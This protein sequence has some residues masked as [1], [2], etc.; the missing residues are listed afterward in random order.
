[1]CEN[2]NKQKE[3]QNNHQFVS[4]K[5]KQ[6]LWIQDSWKHNLWNPASH[7]PIISIFY[8]IRQQW[9]PLEKI[10]DF[11]EVFNPL[12]DIFLSKSDPNH[13]WFSGFPTSLKLTGLGWRIFRLFWT[14]EEALLW[15][16]VISWEL[17][18]FCVDGREM[19][20]G[21]IDR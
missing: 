11:R 10:C 17:K 13:L 16:R 6:I 19:R 7:E 1:M 20:W 3:C 14:F 18:K 21:A 5:V 8:I 12:C 9:R 4:K 2:R 15:S